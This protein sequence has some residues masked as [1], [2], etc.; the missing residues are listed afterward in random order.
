MFLFM[1]IQLYAKDV[2][3][4]IKLDMRIESIPTTN[5][6]SVALF[7]RV[8]VVETNYLWIQSDNNEIL[9]PTQHS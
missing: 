9:L 7:I 4:L 8:I 6:R 5:L 3:C 1:K 2:I